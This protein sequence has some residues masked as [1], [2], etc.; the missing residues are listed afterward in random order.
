MPYKPGASPQ[1]AGREGE[2]ATVADG[3][4]GGAGTTKSAQAS[5]QPA[6]CKMRLLETAACLALKSSAPQVLGTPQL[7]PAH[8]QAPQPSTGYFIGSKT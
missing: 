5:A 2:N 1:V 6:K 4:V 7:R 8:F 3:A